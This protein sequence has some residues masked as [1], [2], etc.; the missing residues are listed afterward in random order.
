MAGK[1]EE[2]ASSIDAQV[3]EAVEK[4]VGEIRSSV[5]D[6]REAVD[7]QLTAALQSVQADVNSMTFLPQITKGK[8]G[9]ATSELQSPCNLVCRLLLEKKKEISNQKI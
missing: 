4:L 2:V 9:R 8:I 6:I 1:G 3:R 5:E 7:Q